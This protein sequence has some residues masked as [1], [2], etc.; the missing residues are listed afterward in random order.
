MS[1][2]TLPE[3]RIRVVIN[4]LRTL[5]SNIL[6][7]PNENIDDASSFVTLG[8][9]SFKAVHLYQKCAEHGLGVRFQDILHKS[10]RDVASLA[11]NHQDGCTS[12]RQVKKGDERFSQMPLGYDFAKIFNELRENYNV[13]VDAIEDIYPCSPMQESMYIGQKM[14]SKRL[15]RTRG[16]F[17]AQELDLDQ[18]Q[19]SWNEIV[20]RHQTLRTVYVEASEFNS[21][22]LLDAVVLKSGPQSIIIE[23]VEDLEDISHQFT[24][25]DLETVKTDQDGCQ[26]QI[27]IYVSAREPTGSRVLFHMDLNHLTVDGSSLMIIIDEL[28]NGLQCSRQPGPAPGYGRYIDYL[29]TQADED[30][31]L[32]YWVDYLDG[33]E[34]CFFPALDDNKTQAG[35]AGSFQV[36][37]MPLT[38]TLD[39][40][41]A[42]CQKYNATISN[43]LQAVWSLVLYTY[44]GDSDICFGY[45][46]SGRSLP[47]PG[48]AQIVGPMM[49]LLVSRVGGVDTM[50]LKDL[51]ETFRD[52]FLNALPHQCFS[53]SKVQ[54]ILGT[55]ETKLFNTIMTSYYSPYM[56]GDSSSSLFKLIAS[57]NASDFDIVLKAVYS[58][59]DI[60][61]RL[62]YSIAV[63]SPSMAS[64]VSHTFSSI[65]SRLIGMDNAQAAV[66]STT[67]ISSWDMRQV[68]A[69][70]SHMHT[71]LLKAQSTCIHQL[72]QE[73]V[74]LRPT[75]P[76]IHSWDGNMSYKELDEAATI[77]AQE[78]LNLGIGP[79]A[80]VALCF[81]KSK[82]Y[83]VALLGV[84]KSGN[85]FSPVDI[86][87][88]ETRREEILQQLGISENSGLVICSCKQAPSIRHLAG[89]ILQ[90]DQEQLETS[91]SSRV[92]RGG[93]LVA[94]SSD[95]P[96]YVVFT[97]GSTG[98]PKG[99][100]VEHGAY[101]YAAQAHS[102]GIHIQSGSR[103]LQFASYGFDTSMEDHLTT[104]SVGAC[105]CVPS[106]EARM[107]CL[108]L[109][110]FAKRSEANWAH[111]TPSFAE[112][113][114]PV[115]LPTVRTMVLGGEAM[116]A[117]NVQNWAT[118]QTELIQVYGPSECSVTS[119][120]SSPF[121]QGSNPTNIGFPVSGCAAYVARPDDPNMLQA[122][123][124]VGELLME[125][126]ILAR[127][128]L[129]DP[130]KTSTSFV[131]G[132]DWAPRKRLYRTGDLVKYDSFGHLH[133]V[134]RRDG[135]VKLRG[136]RI[137]LGEIERQLVL[138]PRVRQCVALVPK[139]GPCAKRL[140]AVVT[141]NDPF[142]APPIS[143][144]VSRI[145]ILDAPWLKHIDCMRGFLLDKLP[146]YMNP[147]LWI[148]LMAM[149]RNSSGK[150]DRKRVTKYLENL[151]PDEF[152]SLLPRMDDDSP[153]RPGTELEIRL[154]SIWSEVLN[155]CED[156]ICWN[157][158][159]YHL[160]GDSISAITI[161]SMARQIGLNICA[162]D[163][164][165]YRSIERL[166]KAAIGAVSPASAQAN[167][168][169]ESADMQAFTLSPIQK[170][171]F[172]ASP[173]GDA[174]DQQTVLVEA[175][176]NLD[177]Q[178]L[179]KA[180]E[181]ILKTHPMLCARFKCHSK[182]EW[183]QQ[184]PVR[185]AISMVDCCRLRFHSRGQLDYV[186]EC[187]AEAKRS[188]D[189]TNGPLMAVDVFEA[190]CRTLL[191]MTIHHL[192]V[193][194]VSWRILLRELE[195]YLRLGTPIL[196]ETTSFQHWTLEQQRF[197]SSLLPH[198]V[199]P[200]SS[201]AIVTDLSFWGM[202]NNRNC[203]G[204][205]I[206]HTITLDASV[207]EALSAQGNAGHGTQ[208][209]L[210]VA[211]I[212][213]FVEIFGRSPA[214][215]SEGHGR[216]LF[217]PAVDPSNTVGWFTTFSPITAQDHG[218]FLSGIRKFRHMTPL[219]GLEY[220]ASRFLSKAGE[221][222]F[223]H[224]YPM[225]ITLNFLGAFQ[226]FEKKDSLFKPCNDGFQER[227]LS[228]RHQQRAGSSRYALISILASIK[229]S[230]LSLQVEW[231]SRMN[232]QD[233]LVN[234]LHQ[235]EQSLKRFVFSFANM[236]QRLPPSPSEIMVS[237]IGLRRK[238]LN[239]ILGL[240]Q[241]RLGITT[242]EI[243][244]IFPCSPIQDSLILSQLRS[245]NNQYTQRFLFKLSGS[246]PLN[247]ED[248]SAAWKHVVATH[249]ILRTV[250]IENES[251]RFFQLVLKAVN[252]VIQIHK[253]RSEGDL[254]T[255]WAEQSS[256]VAPE[257]L[258]GRI[259]HNLQMY[260][261]GDGSVYCLLEKNHIIT[262]G[263]TSRLLIR[264][265]LAAFD[266]RPRQDTCPYSNYIDCVQN[267]DTA[268]TAQYWSRYLNGAPS[269]QFPVL[270]QHRPS[271]AEM[272]EFTRKSSI[273]PDMG[274][275]SST[276]RKL[277]LT[278]PIIFQAAWSVVLST[279]M[280][281]DDI[282]FG[283]LGH[284]RDIP[285]PG[286][287]EIVGPMANVVPVR[288]QLGPKRKI[289]EILTTLQED[290]IGHLSR[291]TVSLARI[292]HA[293]RRSGDA[294]FNTIL[295]FQKTGAATAAGRIKSELLFAHDTSEYDIALCVTEGQ[296]QFQITI[297][298]PTHFM[299]E[300]QSERLLANYTKALRTIIDDPE[301]QTSN[302]HLASN[303]DQIQLEQWNSSPLETN[304]HCIHDMISETVYRQPSKPAICAWDGELSYAEVDFLSTKLAARLQAQGAAPEEIVVLCFEKSLWAV[305]SMLAVAKSGAAFVHI[306]PNG[307]SKRNQSVIKQTRAR[308][309][310]S[311]PK[312]SDKLKGL[313]ETLVVVDK[314]F[315]ESLLSSSDSDSLSR[316][317]TPL[318]TLYIIFTS[319]TTGTPKG[320]VIQHKSFCSAAASN[321]SWLQIN[322]D[323]RVLQFTNFCF[324][325]S[326][327]EIFTVL[328]AGGCICIPSEEERMSDIPGF[329]ARKQVNWA[330]FTPSFLRTLDPNDLDSVKFITVHA[331]PMGQDLVARWAG[332]IH[333]RPSYGPTECSVTSTVGSPFNVDTDATSIGLPVGCRAWVVH[334]E[335]HHLLMP[336]GA[337]GEL[338]LDG[339]IVGKGYLNDE[340]K[341][342]TAFIEPPLWAAGKN[343]S[344]EY[345]SGSPR[346]LY[347]TGD[348]VRYAEDGSL[349][350]QRR[351]DHSQVKIRG[352]RVELGEIQ[353]HLNNLSGVIQHSMILVPEVGNLA[354][355]LVAVVS[356]TVL[357]SK[358]EAH[359]YNQGV[360]IVEKDSLSR[361]MSQKLDNSMHEIA[362]ALKR[363]LPQYMI[364]ET[365]LIVKSLPVQLSLKLD[366]QRL[367]NWVGQIDQQTVLDSLDLHRIDGLDHQC[368]SPTEETLRGI[369]AEVLGLESHRIA[370][371][372]S[373][374]R[375]GGDSIFAI[376]VMRLCKAASLNVTTQDVL[377]NPTIRL[378]AQTIS[379]RMAKHEMGQAHP[380]S[381]S[382]SASLP[383]SILNPDNVAALVPCSPFQKRMYQ[384][385]LG[386]P[387]S[388]YLFN[389]L[390]E[391][392]DIKG[393]SSVDT[394]ALQ[395]AWQ[396]TVSRHATLRT[397]FIQ[398]L[399]SGNVFQKILKNHKADISV[400]NVKSED[401]A[402]SKSRLH[403]NFVRSKLFNDDSPPVSVRLFVT[404]HRQTFVHFVMGHVLI[405][406]VSLAHLFS[407]FITFYRGQNPG[408]APLSGF[409]DYIDHINTCRRLQASNQY[410]V[411]KLQN[412]PPCMVP[413]E[414]I[415]GTDTGSDPHV[416]ESINFSIDITAKLKQFLCE[417]GVTLS[418]LLQFTW[419][420][421]LHVC[422]GHSIIC[423]GHL[424]SDR[425]IDLPHAHEIVG[426]MLSMMVACA[427]LSEAT[428]ILH[429]LQDFQDESIRSLSHKT[430]E[431]IEVERQLGC[432]GTGLFNTLVNYRKIKY[433]NDL[434][435]GFRSIWKQD[436]HEQLLVL[437]FNEGP[438]RLDATL[439]YYES[440]FSQTTM[441]NLVET[442]RR[443]LALLIDCQYQTVGDVKTELTS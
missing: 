100:V 23:H 439:T 104:F 409:H 383:Q 102:P 38:V 229:D 60:R 234:W 57:H 113:F 69:W 40:I 422:T 410:W 154:R 342:A 187:I 59:S 92:E 261:A 225:E 83:S 146:P 364:P 228:L 32:D 241:S 148:I 20:H 282:V 370:L 95:S 227:I 298:T 377:A 158:S 153:E 163:V 302:M 362:S 330:A 373:F 162:A 2:T 333:M 338:L 281:S 68:T 78:I 350:I 171:H 177:Q 216:E 49:N 164:L 118:P 137:E 43:V 254:P 246:T 354:G 101:A 310:L 53:I 403:L 244:A 278:V 265:F 275:L 224:H 200:P 257:P 155:I 339:P 336:I 382:N 236:H 39:D 279:Y 105:L 300:A 80:F 420:M 126:P 293:A 81:E 111:L 161:S 226:Q 419:A 124:A 308:I 346:R 270:R 247:P 56:S 404:A 45:L 394:S 22:R 109:A 421:L 219:N 176:Q 262:D 413:V 116:T 184:L 264:N 414:S 13:D 297:E 335:N 416:I 313:V 291:Q 185:S 205:S 353:Y 304:E 287:S 159:F 94:T 181:S 356:L 71:P 311:S 167:T 191:S 434:D 367:M 431:L 392:N 269:C 352:Q 99:V 255:L 108:D 165:R 242:S 397:A 428:P 50:S 237:S 266:G 189:L 407:D 396:Q 115:T 5:I 34:P 175:T 369:W 348:L 222:A 103:V 86:S 147:E 135:Q 380:E 305:V 208:D 188:L 47:I 52:D 435:I 160:G 133:F 292:Q 253:L 67:A 326:L 193:D 280:N 196:A 8:G 27:T 24:N 317:V 316:G 198:D 215:F 290:N 412:L 295:N 12:I 207:S 26:H 16:L 14:I 245:V 358:L 366:R 252:V 393:S 218:D 19:A 277:D 411:D 85:A 235:L 294:L 436:P 174:L 263:T 142:S 442:Y 199:L 306:D 127:G 48:V 84:L 347:K 179:L 172:Q 77:V 61:V 243:E 140:V 267:Q 72:I 98:K 259:L 33:A 139:S 112:M 388:P 248:L 321:R 7:V 239:T 25:G 186:V 4:Q 323:S 433:S 152:A 430:F 221:E 240:A 223:K 274:T 91:M 415:T 180:L 437:A 75:A 271:S 134:G 386:K 408:E 424:V 374:F 1:A 210:L 65:L 201:H 54:R 194:A 368:C 441:E 73:Q 213:S 425:D 351:K 150:L 123:G 88:P 349:L 344:S 168:S 315:T 122:V 11:S 178:D 318:N 63:L 301:A 70:N 206:C 170:L 151:T 117:K 332:K 55:N 438:S 197:A 36:A 376:Q 427:S 283:L 121:S 389:S 87:N 423:F 379:K 217:T 195:S 129:G 79:G 285:I 74:R 256:S 149:P 230:E 432:E 35:N 28:V 343:F 131:Q 390:V 361:E 260:T 299:S 341:T 312:H 10:L 375:L 145:E 399:A 144:S 387:Q 429:A 276:C 106:E 136:Q 46:S 334:P 204:D 406:H 378:L 18:F 400:S 418:N 37:E 183:T 114:T 156:E 250:F 381:L 173:K 192:V 90:L 97:S 320:V 21:S 41:R 322:A 220:F 272:L 62:A 426:P 331:E 107:N 417:A 251:G 395:R 76:A 233:L 440:L 345:D 337:I 96:A 44:T 391:L 296:G 231:N 443:L 3:D 119:T 363:E 64:R 110:E 9:D 203:F 303:L 89:Q 141:L 232:H 398:E 268:E 307:A 31:A 289:S 273:I 402:K 371:E 319:G 249:Q 327:E 372:Q 82:W 166:V 15:Y 360:A 329:V 125:G 128:Y 143:M 17:E 130:M 357:A 138:E 324:D 355:R 359:D 120:I 286:A 93:P 209:I 29:Q 405:D 340:V 401:E 190:N 6:M 212:E 384:A 169:E 325:A 214:L 30:G 365:W 238:E 202:A 157:T 211:V 132:L 288:V 42:F 258:S 314:T 182:G 58:D 309:G 51:L 328:V 66:N 284:G 385:F